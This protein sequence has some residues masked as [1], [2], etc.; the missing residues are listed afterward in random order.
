MAIISVGYGSYTTTLPSGV[1]TPSTFQGVPLSPEVST[2]FT[3]PIPTNDWASSII[4]PHFGDHYSAPL[5]A[6]PMNMQA[7]AHGLNL[8]YTATPTMYLDNHGGQFKFEYTYHPDISIGL[9]DMNSADTRM[10]KSS[11][12]F[13]QAVWQDTDSNSQLHATFGHGSPFTFFE[14][15]GDAPVS[16]NLVANNQNLIGQPTSTNEIF[17]IEHVNG[18]YDGGEISM[19]LLVNAVAGQGSEVGNAIEARVSI[20]TNG[21][22]KFDYVKTMNYFPLDGSGNTTENYLQSES[23]RSS[24][25]SEL[26]QL[27]NLSDATIQVEVWKTFGTGDVSVQT[28][29]SSVTLPFNNMQ[30]FLSS[31]GE[32][33]TLMTIPGAAS[34][35]IV[36][37]VGESVVSWDGPGQIFYFDGNVL[38]I[39]IN[40]N[41]YGLF[42]PVGSEWNLESG[43]ITSDLSGKDYFS[44][45][46]L[47]DD[48]VATLQ[49][50]YQHAYAFVTDSDITFSYDENNSTVTTNFEVTTELKEPG[51]SSEALTALYPHQWLNSSDALT[52]YTYQVPQGEMKLHEGNSFTTETLYTGVLPVLPN[53]LD[54]AQQ[55]QLSTLID[56][57]YHHLAA[58]PEVI[59]AQDAYWSGKAMA[60]LGE[61]AQLA[62]QV[63]NEDA[64]I[65]FIDT[66]KSELQD[67]FT[68]SDAE[69]DKQFYYNSEWNTLQAYPSGFNSDTELNDHHFHAGYL[70]KAA[71]VVAQFDPQWAEEWGGMVDLVIQDVANTDETNVMFP[72]LRNFDPY[73]GHS[74][75]N[76]HGAFFS[77]NNHESSSE[78]MQLASALTLW[79]AETGNDALQE[80]GTY[81][82]STELSAIQQYWFDVDGINFPA[83]FDHSTIGMV[84]GDGAVY[85]TWFSADPEMIHGINYLPVTAASLY[86]GLY[87]ENAAQNYA[88]I[89]QRNGGPPNQW[90][91]ILREYQAFF[92]SEAALNGYNFNYTPEEGESYA[93]TYAWLHN[94]N[95]L[96]EVNRFVTADTPFY[97]V[98]DQDGLLT[99]VAY[100]PMDAEQVITF[101]DGTTLTLDAHETIAENINQS[102]SSVT[103]MIE[104][105][106]VPNPNLDPEPEPEPE[107][108]LNPDPDPDPDPD[109]ILIPDGD[110]IIGTNAGET[111]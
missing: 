47:P 19:N 12:Y 82:F 102:W 63:G 10:E 38:G 37:S 68:A 106:T 7:D 11:A 97:A 73:A 88:E 95:A 109:P 42:A 85:G 57:E 41:S 40:G 51:F 78:A 84:W 108:E 83:N 14:R 72:V 107:P 9:S 66:I 74:W 13:N 2:D 25:A 86:L 75:A 27:G 77:G 93:H 32:Q 34:E 100:N 81:L 62:D 35:L 28:G 29:S 101:S 70:V 30:L 52:E 48:S 31:D 26:G 45:A 91:D 96:G 56:V 71:A 69:G 39:T 110:E 99:Y 23:G 18:V 1:L 17:K 89:V 76:G 79:G 53:F 80:L 24:G 104:H 54:D 16:I 61:L 90:T 4:Y 60:R 21:D 55:Q 36:G 105:E 64:K 20:D 44:A 92:D 50:F 6:Q 15:T 111:I 67:W 5:F 46:L 65:F 87:P 22:G 103:G 98:F 8:G 59:T 49:N 3:G 43:Q 94:M 58:L 33:N